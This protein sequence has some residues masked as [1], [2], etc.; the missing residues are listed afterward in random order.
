MLCES[1]CWALGCSDGRA[2]GCSDGRVLDESGCASDGRPDGW[3]DGW[4]DGWA[5]GEPDGSEPGVAPG[6]PGPDVGGV[7]DRSGISS[8]PGVLRASAGSGSADP[9]E[10]RAGDVRVDVTA[11]VVS[12]VGS[13]SVAGRMLVAGLSVLRGLTPARGR[14]P[15]GA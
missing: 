8:R 13:S 10:L 2:L 5:L 14:S 15:S 1:G 6:L 7:E 12:A 11:E 4:S 9:S 3:S